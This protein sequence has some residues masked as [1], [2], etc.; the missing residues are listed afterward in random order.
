MMALLAFVSQVFILENLGYMD[1]I[2]RSWALAK[3]D[4]GRV[5]VVVLLSSILLSVIQQIPTIPLQI[6]NAM[7]KTPRTDLQVLQVVIGMLAQILV[8]PVQ[9]ILMVLLYY[10]IRVR[11][12]GFDIQMLAQSIGATLPAAE[13]VPAQPTAYYTPQQGAVETPP[14]PEPAAEPDSEPLV[15]SEPEPEQP[16][17]DEPDSA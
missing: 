6:I 7:D 16:A 11:K 14:A 12:E 5:I 13:I 17:P 10:D 9:A 2:R 1:A 8:L 4:L 15:A 3:G